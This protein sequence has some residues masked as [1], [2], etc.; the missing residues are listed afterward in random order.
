MLNKWKFKSVQDLQQS[1]PVW[2]EWW[3]ATVWKYVYIW[4][5]I[6]NRWKRYDSDEYNNIYSEINIVNTRIDNITD[7]ITIV[8]DTT[9]DGTNHK[10]I[11]DATSNNIII[12]LPTAVWIN[13]K[14]YVITRSDNSSNLVTIE[15]QVWETIFWAPNEQ[16]FQYET[17]VFSSDN[18]NYL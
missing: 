18:T 5:V 16:L 15:P 2:K 7:C 1:Y 11:C 6:V 10:V 3:T 13:W 4:D 17:L 9:L 8:A 14:E 12:T